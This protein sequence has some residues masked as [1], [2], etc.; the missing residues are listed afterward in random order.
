MQREKKRKKTNVKKDKKK[1]KKKKKKSSELLDRKN[2]SKPQRM[3]LFVAVL[4]CLEQYLAH[5]RHLIKS[6]LCFEWMNTLLTPKVIN[7]QKFLDLVKGVNI[8]RSGSQLGEKQ[9]T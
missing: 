5:N 7:K 8:L 3:D 1:K 9:P 6:C 4:Y 2:Q